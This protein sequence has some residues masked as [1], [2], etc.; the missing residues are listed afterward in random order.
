MDGDAKLPVVDGV[1]R[2][3]DNPRCL[4]VY[5]RTEPTDDEMR[6]LHEMLVATTKAMKAH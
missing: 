6:A 1:G 4:I 5:T 3:A 2:D